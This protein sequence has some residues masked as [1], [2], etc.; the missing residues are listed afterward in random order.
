[1]SDDSKRGCFECKHN[2]ICFAYQNINQTIKT[3]SHMFGKTSR[4]FDV[5]AETCNRFEYY[6]PT[7]GTM[8]KSEQ[9]Y[10]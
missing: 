9:E 5:L 7:V 1:M 3:M 6:N 2:G 8:M 4:I 10:R